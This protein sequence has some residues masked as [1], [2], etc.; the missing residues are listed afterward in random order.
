MGITTNQKILIVVSSLNVGGT[1]RH[2]VQVLPRLNR[3]K[4]NIT[5]YVTHEKGALSS[6]VEEKGIKIYYSR[7]AKALHR[8]GKIAK[9]FAYIAS[10]LGLISLM[11]RLRPKIVHCY[12]PGPYLLGALSRIIT[13]RPFLIMSRRIVYNANEKKSLLYR[14][15]KFLHRKLTAATACSRAILND[16][17]REGLSERK[18]ALISNGIDLESYKDLQEKN[19]AREQLNLQSS[20]LLIVITANLYPRKAHCDLLEALS[21]IKNQLPADWT[22]LCLGRDTGLLSALQQKASQFGI[23]EHILWLGERSDVLTYLRAA[24]IGV[25]CS[26]EEGFSNALL[27]SMLASLPMI[28]TDISGNNEAIEQDQSGLIVPPR[29]PKDL[30]TAILD[31]ANNPDKRKRLGNNAR[32]RVSDKFSLD[33]CVS[34]Y[35]AFYKKLLA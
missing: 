25:L 23:E 17:K 11:L 24:D 13:R 5:I 30:G 27:E 3:M 12:L 14:I 31:L 2:L 35:E 33:S 20:S 10:M 34:N 28:V 16:L 22:L 9:P 19:K 26:H 29:S 4:F 18:I 21:I 6:L 15:E 7:S 1:E 8:F 32:Q